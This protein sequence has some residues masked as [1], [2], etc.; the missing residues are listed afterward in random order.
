VA[1]E[2]NREASMSEQTGDAMSGDVYLWIGINLFKW[3]PYPKIFK[4]LT[5]WKVT[6]LCYFL[7]PQ[8][9]LSYQV[10]RTLLWSNTYTSK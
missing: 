4:S 8:D 7:L 3:L 2:S 10:L 9:K 5:S 6:Y 1:G